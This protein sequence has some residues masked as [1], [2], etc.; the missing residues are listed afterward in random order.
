MKLLITT[1]TV[2]IHDPILG[3][4]HAWIS[5]FAKHF[6]HVYVICLKKG[7]SSLP[8]N[9][10]VF[11]LGKERGVT[12]ATYIMRF[13]RFF[14]HVFFRE[15]VS[16]VFFHMGAIYNILAAPFFLV[17]RFFNTSF[18]WWKTHGKLNHLKERL[19]LRVVDRVYTAGSKSFDIPTDKV[20]VVGHAIDTTVFTP[21][22]DRAQPTD[23]TALI[24]GRI[25]PIKKIEIALDALAHVLPLTPVALRII[26]TTNNAA[27]AE[28]LHRDVEA[29]NLHTVTFVGPKTQ[30]EVLAEYQQASLLLHPAYEAGFDKV[31]L[32]AMAAGV[33]PITSIPSFKAILEPYGLYVPGGDSEGYARTMLRIVRYTPAERQMLEK[34]LRDEVCTHH[35][36]TTLPKRIF[37]L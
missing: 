7:V 17:R 33:I 15:R 11:S 4:F 32:E 21:R 35:T 37:E 23:T 6:D 34:A 2:D 22:S 26:G 13:Y 25:T 16:Y 1:Q 29:R 19:A 27:Y 18:Y 14:A 31:V 12:R 3:F 5:E 10:T 8:E 9:V 30:T 36:L 20:R 28:S 24:V